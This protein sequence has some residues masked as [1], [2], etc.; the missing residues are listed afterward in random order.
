MN[1]YEINEETLAVLALDKDKSKVIEI[2]REIIINS[3]TMDI[4]DRSC[5]FFGSSYKGRFDGTKYLI[6]LSHKA[7][8]IIEETRKIIFFPTSSPRNDMCDWI[9]LNNLDNYYKN[10]KNTT[11]KFYCGKLL[12]LEINYGVLDNQVLRAT[13]LEAVLNKKLKKDKNN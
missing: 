8:I 10:K 3:S 5:K 1:R 4:I 13:R 6:N 11:L 9:S 2:E 12:T 7:P